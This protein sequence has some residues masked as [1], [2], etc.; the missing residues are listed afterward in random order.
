MQSLLAPVS[1]S[2]SVDATSSTDV[3]SPWLGSSDLVGE[4]AAGADLQRTVTQA[5]SVSMISWFCLRLR[6]SPERLPILCS[7][8]EQMVWIVSM[9][10]E[11]GQHGQKTCVQGV[12]SGSQARCRFRS[13]LFSGVLFRGC[14]I[15]RTTP[16][17]PQQRSLR[18]APRRDSM[19]RIA[20]ALLALGDS[21][22]LRLPPPRTT[23]RRT[24]IASLGATALFALSGA[25]PA[26]ASVPQ[27]GFIFE[28]D[29]KEGLSPAVR[30]LRIVE[31]TEFQEEMLRKSAALSNEDRFAQGLMVGP[32]QLKMSVDMLLQN[33]Q[34]GELL[35]CAPAVRT[36]N[37]IQSLADRSRDKLS[38]KELLEAADQY[39]V[40]R[41]QVRQAFNRLSPEEQMEGISLA[42]R[43]RTSEDERAR[44]DKEAAAAA[45]GSMEV[46]Q[47]LKEVVVD[48]E[49]RRRKLGQRTSA[50]ELSQKGVERAL[51]GE[52]KVEISFKGSPFEQLMK[53]LPTRP[54]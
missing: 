12:F 4:R 17:E 51:Y 30:M 54:Q 14:G 39:A 44:S 13:L 6:V 20:L 35:A 26:T 23:D 41:G 45:E 48:S 40:A 47:A 15:S 16:I 46:Q 29:L 25:A 18:L 3:A 49:V 42:L 38:P 9:T 8:Q 36:F 28:E 5:F 34:L 37:G 27:E 32:D 11:V 50:N 10:K 31:Q 21:R 53:Q 24:A 1:P 43:L 33:S 2:V 52:Q 22:A 7:E 19:R